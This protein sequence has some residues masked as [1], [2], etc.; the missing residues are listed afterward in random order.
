MA[1]V[2]RLAGVSIATV[3]YVVNGT[4]QVREETRRRVE[5]AIEQTGYT[6]N[7][8][9][10]SL[11][12]SSTESI[13]VVISAITNPY[14]AEVLAGVDRAAVRAG[15]ILL[16]ADS[17]DEPKYEFEVVRD[18]C[19]RRV[20]GIVLAPSTDPARTLDYLV[21]SKVPTV[22]VDRLVDDRFDQ[23]GPENEEST[24]HLV[25][26]LAA[27][28][29]RRIGM[30]SGLSGLGT[31][32]ERLA[33]YRKGLK[34]SRLPYDASLVAEGHSNTVGAHAATHR[35]LATPEPPTALIVGNNAMI[36]G[37]M[38]ALRG[39]GLLVPNDIALV[40]YDDLPGADLLAPPLTAF[41]QPC[42][43]L[44]ERAIA[45][46]LQR[47]TDPD[48]A[49]RTERLGPRLMH[50][51]SCGCPADTRADGTSDA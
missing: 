43:Q 6:P 46:L 12:T 2:A 8:L 42:A 16:L 49:P 15:R 3:S 22:L 35:L 37:S 32:T 47:L 21:A 7:T 19:Q 18:L 9:A 13:G 30:I 38:R 25:Q 40:S 48:A 50:R 33:G 27:R 28:G 26:H 44:G 51:R 14:F 23:V 5:R 1:E 4:R 36:V 41:A 11:A 10:R 24:A 20:D 31:T 17:H 45:M 34:R 29:H 39:A